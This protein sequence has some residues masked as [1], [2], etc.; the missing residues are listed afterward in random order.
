MT[1][2]QTTSGSQDDPVVVLPGAAVGDWFVLHAKPRQ[3]KALAAALEQMHIACFL[4]LQNL[5]RSHGGRKTQVELPLFP[6]YLFLRGSVEQAYDADRTRRVVSIIRVVDQKQIEDDLLNI[7]RALRGKAPL[8][9]YPYLKTGI[10]AEVRAGAL[11]GL[12]GIIESRSS[13]QRLILRV[14]TLGRAVSVEIDGSLL[15]P[16]E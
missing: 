13:P 14:Q 9:P 16:L 5:V 10:R 1:S 4:P 11:R 12:Q 6:G 15:D 7:A 8:L 3:E 2:S